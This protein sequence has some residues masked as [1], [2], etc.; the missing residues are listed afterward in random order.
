LGQAYGIE[1][2]RSAHSI[3][4]NSIL[5]NSNSSPLEKLHQVIDKLSPTSYTLFPSRGFYDWHN[6]ENKKAF[7]SSL[8]KEKP[9]YRLLGGDLC[10]KIIEL[11]F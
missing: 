9:I 4:L 11:L 10:P 3:L 2:A 8:L 5:L 6:L 7:F 1:A